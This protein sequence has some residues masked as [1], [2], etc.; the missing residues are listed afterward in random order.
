[1]GQMKWIYTMV[2]D[3]TSGVFKKLYEN[4]VKYK[5][6]SFI[7]ESKSFTT[8]RARAVIGAIE[9]AEAEYDQWID[10]QAEAYAEWQ[11]EIIRGK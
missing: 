6:E 11:S 2:Q 1:M 7:F 8:D 4:A 10:D 3:G 9:H 5:L